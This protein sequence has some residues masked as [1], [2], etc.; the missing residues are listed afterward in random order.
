MSGFQRRRLELA[1]PCT[2]LPA[3]PPNAKD[4]PTSRSTFFLHLLRILSL[5]AAVGLLVALAV[6]LEG[7]SHMIATVSVHLAVLTGVA[8]GSRVEGRAMGIRL[9][10]EPLP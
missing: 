9:S 10:S 4:G 6:V 5:A 2:R 8:A 1:L 7:G 3:S